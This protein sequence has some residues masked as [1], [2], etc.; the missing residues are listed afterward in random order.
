VRELWLIDPYGPAGTQFFQRVQEAL[1]EVAPI[2]GA[3]HSITLRGFKLQTA[4]LWPD[5]SG[6]LPNPYQ[7]LKD[8]GAV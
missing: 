5:A 4:W 8:L 2:D 3:I 6:S 1:V 7:V